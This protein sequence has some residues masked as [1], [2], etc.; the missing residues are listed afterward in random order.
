M[1]DY[2]NFDK[3]AEEIKQLLEQVKEQISTLDIDKADF[4]KLTVE[5]QIV[6][7]ADLRQMAY[8]LKFIK[9]KL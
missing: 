7:K 6:L 8:K 5:G 1:D 3:P 2:K 9:D 4:N